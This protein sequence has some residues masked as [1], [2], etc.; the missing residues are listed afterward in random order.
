M[1]RGRQERKGQARAAFVWASRGLQGRSGPSPTQPFG[2][3]AT[4]HPPSSQGPAAHC[5]QGCLFQRWRA[6]PLE[7]SAAHRAEISPFLNHGIV[8]QSNPC[9]TQLS[10]AILSLLSSQLVISSSVPILSHHD[11]PALST[12]HSLLLNKFS[13]R[14]MRKKGWDHFLIICLC[15]FISAGNTNT[16]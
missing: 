3:R 2:H 5:F 16:T 11:V 1:E 14:G 4:F 7:S 9:F 6:C 12:H 15:H 13:F 10:L 8:D